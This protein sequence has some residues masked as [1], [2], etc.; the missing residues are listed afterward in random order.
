MVNSTFFNHVNGKYRVEVSMEENTI[1]LAER[2]GRYGAHIK[3]IPRKGVGN[4]PYSVADPTPIVNF[5]L[6][7]PGYLPLTNR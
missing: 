2:Y 5:I 4:H 7:N 1:I 3:I 6:S